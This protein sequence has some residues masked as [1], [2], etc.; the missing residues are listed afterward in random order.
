MS[1]NYEELSPVLTSILSNRVDGIVREMSN[2]LMRTARSAVINSARDFS[3]CIVTGQNELLA[4]AEGLPVHIFGTDMQ[5]RV[6]TELHPDMAEGDCYLHNDPYSGNTHAADHAFMVPV[7]YENEHL[8]TAVAKA[9]Q[10]DCGNSLPTTYMA[11]A[12]DVYNEGALIFPATRIQRNYQMIGDVVRMMERRIRVP[13]Q[14]YG[15]FLAGISAARV[16][17]KRLKEMCQKYGKDVVKRFISTWL[18][19]SEKRMVRAIEKLPRASLKNSGRHDSTAF[20]PEGVALQVKIEVLP[21]SGK[22]QIDLRDN[23]DNVDCG[24]NQ[25]QATATSSVLAG[26]FNSLEGDIPKN[27]GS[28]RRVEVLLREGCVTGIPQFP[29][30]CSVATTNISDRMVN[31]TGAAFAQLG[32]GYGIAEGGLGPGIGMAVIGGKDPRYDNENFVNQIHLC[33]N[34]GPASPFA[35]GW[36]TYGIPVVAGLMYRD[37]IEV[38]EL[39]HPIEIKRLELM[40]G[41]GGAGKY[42]GAPGALLEFGIKS[43]SMT[44]LYPGDGQETSP[45]GVRGG[46]NGQLA[47]RWHVRGSGEKIKLPNAAQIEMKGADRVIGIDCSGGGYGSPLERDPKRVLNDVMELYE[48]KARAEKIYGVVLTGDIHND[49]LQIDLPATEKRRQE[50]A[51]S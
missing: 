18:N 36:V 13:E 21:E 45:K 14:W 7:F 22:I 5:T 25:S 6:M 24:Y 34:G 11:V 32:D 42:R 15:D 17:E 46:Q 41:S 40:Q 30:S 33:T 1:T 31:I 50:L 4:V 48:T 16:A 10:A 49:T 23:P 3:C 8:F 9:H 39:K 51:A 26:L 28:F 27:A 20:L 44:L 47:E 43:Q 35:D 2:T 38:D 29:H 19:Y 37:S 12:Q